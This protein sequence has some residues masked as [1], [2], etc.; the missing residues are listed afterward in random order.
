MQKLRLWFSLFLVVLLIMVGN[1][2]HNFSE[3]GASYSEIILLSLNA[4]TLCVVSFF[5]MQAFSNFMKMIYWIFKGYEG[6]TLYICPILLFRDTENKCQK[7]HLVFAPLMHFNTLYPSGFMLKL[8]EK[9]EEREA[10]KELIF[11]E[12]YGF[13]GWI[14]AYF[15]VILLASLSGN[16]YLIAGAVSTIVPTLVI[17]YFKEG[18]FHGSMIKVRNT[19]KGFGIFYTASSA[20]L[21][22]SR[23]NA[24]YRTFQESLKRDIPHDFNLYVLKTINDIFLIRCGQNFNITK[25]TM[26]YIENEVIGK[27]ATTL[28]YAERWDFLKVFMC[29]AMLNNCDTNLNIALSE[30]SEFH[31]TLG[32]TKS[33]DFIAWHMNIGLHRRIGKQNKKWFKDSII[34][35]DAFKQRF[36]NYNFI[37]KSIIRRIEEI[38]EIE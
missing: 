11:C 37:T 6:V 29:Y 25:A 21:S 14:T 16:S 30:M 28:G 2:F 31:E 18:A 34:R 8:A 3:Y 33:G 7:F 32:I 10:N 9:Y 23:D 20:I 26:N 17:A 13:V 19:I 22:L 15:V 35:I 36:E 4:V 12:I 27:S 5:F 1:M 38:C 24:I